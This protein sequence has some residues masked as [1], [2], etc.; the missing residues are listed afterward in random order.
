MAI[1]AKVLVMFAGISIAQGALAQAVCGGTSA[2][3]VDRVEKAPFSAKRRITTITRKSDG[4]SRR[5]EATASEARDGNGRRYRAGE[6]RWTTLIGNERVP[7]SEILVRISDPIDNTDTEWSSG[8]KEVRVI[9]WPRGTGRSGT[10]ERSPD[11][12]LGTPT[13]D[14]NVQKLGTKTIEG[15]LVEGVR[16]S[17]A[18]PHA[19][20]K[21]DNQIIV[22]H[23]CWYSPDFK[24]VIL[25]TDDDPRSSNF[26]NQLENIVRGEPDVAKYQPPADYVRQ[27]IEIPA[28]TP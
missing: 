10:E 20:A 18:V 1:V 2:D 26:T 22:V 14:S 3:A 17:Y 12:F 23:E 25:E 8:S 21:G 13:Q 9:H 4:T 6:R 24:V 19:Q 5:N 7:Q 27:N 15:V 16:T 11:P 28:P